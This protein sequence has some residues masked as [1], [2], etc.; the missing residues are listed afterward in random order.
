MTSSTY[1]LDVGSGCGFDFALAQPDGVI[2]M[3]LRPVAS[4]DLDYLGPAQ[5]SEPGSRDQHMYS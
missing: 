2:E 1:S 3:S 5:R 4:N